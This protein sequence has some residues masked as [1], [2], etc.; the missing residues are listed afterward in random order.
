MRTVQF[1]LK[2][3]GAIKTAAFMAGTGYCNNFAGL[4]IIP[5]D[6]MV[7]RIGD[8]NIIYFVD[9]EVLWSVEIGR[10]RS[11]TNHR[12]DQTIPVDTP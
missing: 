4:R 2:R 7:L 10:Y 12:A 8:N 6:Q 9:A 1:A 3:I 11:R 5:P